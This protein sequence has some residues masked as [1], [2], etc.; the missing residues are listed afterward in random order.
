MR[1]APYRLIYMAIEMAREVGDFF[2][3][4]DLMSCK[5]AAKRPVMPI[6]KKSE[7]HYCSLLCI[8]S[9]YIMASRRLQLMP[10]W[11]SLPMAGER[12]F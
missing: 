2:S 1:S 4:V 7:L 3:V 5:T 10:F 6:K 12:L 8:S 9:S 11:L